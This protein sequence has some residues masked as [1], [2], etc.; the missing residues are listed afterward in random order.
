MLSSFARLSFDS[1]LGYEANS[2]VWGL[3][4][5]RLDPMNLETNGSRTM[6]SFIEC[7][8]KSEG[9][10]SYCMSKEASEW[11]KC[12]LRVPQGK[13]Q[14]NWSTQDAAGILY[15]Q[16]SPS[17]RERPMTGWVVVHLLASDRI[18]RSLTSLFFFICLFVKLNTVTFVSSSS[19]VLS[20]QF[21]PLKDLKVG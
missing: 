17:E 15:F 6:T 4:D 12:R 20:N 16:A 8:I 19:G 1:V 13:S 2:V 21:L 9:W 3:S 5:Y 11:T 14:S 18:C 7:P 10:T